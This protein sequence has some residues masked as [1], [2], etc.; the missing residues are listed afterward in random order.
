MSYSSAFRWID[1]LNLGTCV[2]VYICLKLWMLH[3]CEVRILGR[4]DPIHWRIRT[5]GLL[6]QVGKSKKFP[7]GNFRFEYLRGVA[8]SFSVYVNG[9]GSWLMSH[10]NLFPVKRM[11]LKDMCPT[12]RYTL[13]QAALYCGQFATPP[14]PKGVGWRIVHAS[15]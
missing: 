11:L 6:V 7:Q 10:V 8:H 12:K 15:L 2:P 1:C 9:D 5:P 14:H 13:G 3:S 4:A